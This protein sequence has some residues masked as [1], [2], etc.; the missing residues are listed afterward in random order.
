MDFESVDLTPLPQLTKE[1]ARVKHLALVL[2]S[3][4][5]QIKGSVSFMPLA[6]AREIVHKEMMENLK[7]RTVN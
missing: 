7:K 3:K 4:I 2:P 6:K 5:A 1:G